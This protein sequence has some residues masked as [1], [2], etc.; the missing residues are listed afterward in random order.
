MVVAIITTLYRLGNDRGRGYKT[1]VECYQETGNVTLVLPDRK[2]SYS[3]IITT[4]PKGLCHLNVNI[5]SFGAFAEKI[6]GSMDPSSHLL[7]V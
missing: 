7:W 5:C 4:D 3:V 6:N 2:S 1:N